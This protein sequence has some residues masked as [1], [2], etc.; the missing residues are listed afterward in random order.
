MFRNLIQ[1]F[2]PPLKR[3]PKNPP[4]S[5][6]AANLVPGRNCG[7]CTVCCK[8][9]TIISSELKK[10]PGIL[11]KHAEE[12]AGCGIY[13]H[14]PAVCRNWYCGW[15]KSSKLDDSWRPDRCGVL[16]EF[17][18]SLE[19]PASYGSQEAVKL[20]IWS[21]DTVQWEPLVT[22]VAA[23]VDARIPVFLSVGMRAGFAAGMAFLNDGMAASVAARDY[24]RVASDLAIAA[25]ICAKH[26]GERI[27]LD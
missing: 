7:G 21:L 17:S 16:M 24:Q 1:L 25:N 8:S 15:R 19:I 3:Q 13:N 22:F 5:S 14:R 26:P 4:S 2:W 18:H 27:V 12:G 10:L 6:Q 20:S 11:C 9:L 23:C